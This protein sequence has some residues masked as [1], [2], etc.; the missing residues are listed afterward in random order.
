VI[1][2]LL[3][4]RKIWESEALTIWKH[5]QPDKVE[6][7]DI[8]DIAIDFEVNEEEPIDERDLKLAQDILN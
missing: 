8:E 2:R 3:G 6:I 7:E 5:Y 4:I 1:N